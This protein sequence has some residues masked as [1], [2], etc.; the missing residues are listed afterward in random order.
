VTALAANDV[1]LLGIGHTNAHVLR[2]WRMAPLKGT[3]LTCVSNEAVAAYSGM[4]PGVLAGQYPPERM[5]IDLV[6]LTAAAG[7][8]LIIDDVTSLDPARQALLF[9]RRAPVHFDVLSVGIGSVPGWGGVQAVDGRRIVPIKPMQTFLSRLEERLQAA[10]AE[11]RREA[12][13]ILVVG[14]GADG[15]EVTLCLP[16]YLRRVLGADVRFELRLVTADEQLLSGELPRT[17]RRIERLL[18]ARGVQARTR[19]PVVQVSDRSVTLADGKPLEADVILWATGAAAPPVLA[20]LN[21]PTDGRGFL[22]TDETLRT[23]TGAPVF[24][25]GDTGT[26]AGAPTPKAGV[27]A[28]RQ[29][30]VVWTNIQRTL[31][32]A[33][34]RR[35]TPQRG[36]LKLLNT[37]DGSAIAEWRGATFEGAWCWRLKDFIDRR[38]IR[39]YQDYTRTATAGHPGQP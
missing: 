37:G 3:R 33:P 10:A 19:S 36:F 29:G 9:D 18:G 35:Y 6:R 25:V 20:R 28:V 7:A 5:E 27:Y 1:V 23:T 14:G 11:R 12:V 39:K 38:F 4:L 26:I 15:V 13:R 21:L 30:P 24:A 31:S 34:L 8:R 2:M 32:G 16:P 22:L 17:T